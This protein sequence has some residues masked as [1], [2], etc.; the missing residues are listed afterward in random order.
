MSHSLN[1]LCIHA[2]WS[3]KDRMPLIHE[4]VEHKIHEYL[5]TQLQE[6][7]CPVRIIN[8]IPDHIHCLFYLTPQL[9]LADVLKQIKGSSSHYIN[10]NDIIPEKFA[11]Q[12]GYAAFSVD[13]SDSEKVFLYIINQ[14]LHNKTVSFGQELEAFLKIHGLKPD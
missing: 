6:L 2:I 1:K 8:R 14:K 13:N 11:W 4:N 3:T 12:T 7:N 10:Q 5:R 9:S